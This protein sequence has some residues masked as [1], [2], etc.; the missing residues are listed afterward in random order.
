[1]QSQTEFGNGKITQRQAA[2]IAGIGLVLMT[3]LAIFANFGVFSRLN[4]SGD[5]ATTLSNLIASEGLFRVAI[6]TFLGIV[7]LDVI[8]AWGLY[9]FLKPQHAEFSLLATA[10]RLVYAAIYGAAIFQLFNVATL[11][12]QIGTDPS[13]VMLSLNAFQNGWM[14]ALI[15]FAFHLLTLGYIFIR[16]KSLPT[17]IGILL[18]LAGS[19]YLIDSTAH[20]LMVNY[21][22]YA[23][24]F[25]AIVAVPAM[26]GEMSM[27]IWLLIKG[28]KNQSKPQ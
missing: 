27:M 20:I 14:I 28:G 22:Q 2:L 1:M 21:D 16:G 8:V 3:V 9:Y 15:V 6:V 26:L 19:A 18:L 23:G 17:V 25:Q 4:V 24:V 13:A 11:I 5:A 7:V 10:F 12:G